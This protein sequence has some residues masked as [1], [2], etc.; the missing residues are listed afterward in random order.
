MKTVTEFNTWIKSHAD[1]GIPA[2][3]HN[4]YA[5]RGWENWPKL[6]NNGNERQDWVSYDEASRIVRS[7]GLKTAAQFSSWVKNHKVGVPAAPQK[8]Y[9]EWIGWSNFLGTEKFQPAAVA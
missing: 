5:G 9:A 4:T 8:Y 7:A 3:P 2:A 1:L 6:L